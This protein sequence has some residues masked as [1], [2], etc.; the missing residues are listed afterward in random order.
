MLRRL[1]ALIVLGGGAFAGALAFR[2]RS[3]GHAVVD[4]HF[5]DGSLVSF[6][7]RSAE[8]QRLLP[9]ARDIL[10]AVDRS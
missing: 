9:F 2:R 7:P 6:G 10:A 8:A 4:V 1:L 3:G 5:D